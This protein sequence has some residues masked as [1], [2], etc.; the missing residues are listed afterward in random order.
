MAETIV[1]MGV[2]RMAVHMANRDK[3]DVSTHVQL[4]VSFK[5]HAH[6]SQLG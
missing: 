1:V 3:K 2:M 5:E 6:Y 4:R